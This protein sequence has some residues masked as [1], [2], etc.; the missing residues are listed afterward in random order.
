MIN[1]PTVGIF[2][3]SA[4]TSLAEEV[5]KILGLKLGNIDLGKV[6]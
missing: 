5:G 3:G 4:S 2:A 1:K 6:F